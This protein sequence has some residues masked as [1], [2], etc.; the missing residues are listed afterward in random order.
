M[1]EMEECQIK[2]PALRYGKWD[3]NA[4]YIKQ[5]E[6]ELFFDGFRTRTRYIFG[7]FTCNYICI[8]H[9]HMLKYSLNNSIS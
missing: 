5:V 3:F 7:F 8:Y 2:K 1:A 4:L 6:D 9:L